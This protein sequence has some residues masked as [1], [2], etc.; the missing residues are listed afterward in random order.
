[1]LGDASQPA[2]VPAPGAPPTSTEGQ[3]GVQPDSTQ[4]APQPSQQPTLAPRK[5]GISLL[6]RDLARL[7]VEVRLIYSEC[8]IQQLLGMNVK[9]GDEPPPNPLSQAKMTLMKSGKQRPDDPGWK[10]YRYA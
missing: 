8:L 2:P 4:Q 5:G 7:L 3:Q 6:E 10:E 9:V 1:M